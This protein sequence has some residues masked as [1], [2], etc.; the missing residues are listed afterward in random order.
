MVPNDFLVSANRMGK[1][2]ATKSARARRIEV[3]LRNGFDKCCY[4]KCKSIERNDFVK[5][6]LSWKDHQIEK[7]VF[8]LRLDL[9]QQGFDNK[10]IR[11]RNLTLVYDAVRID[12]NASLSDVIQSLND[13]IDKR[14]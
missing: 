5:P 14:G 13:E 3:K 8:G 4:D 10:V 7:S 6:K 1:F 12:H 9:I 2:E 11:I